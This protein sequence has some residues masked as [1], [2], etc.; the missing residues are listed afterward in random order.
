MQFLKKHIEAIS[1]ILLLLVCFFLYFFALGEYSL[2]DVD[3][4][5]YVSM[6]KDMFNTKDFLTLYLNKEIFFEKPPLYFWSECLSFALFGKITEA[7]ARFPVALYGTLSCFMVYF[8]G[9]KITSRTF[10][11]VSSLILATSL[12]F[13]ILAK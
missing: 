4:S 2:V 9:R 6:S 7:T 1:L 11:V 13:L 8:I 3:E 12:E 10:G 5:R